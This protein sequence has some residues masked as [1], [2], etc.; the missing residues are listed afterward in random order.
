MVTD[1][2]S[3][4][5]DCKHLEGGSEQS[6]AQSLDT[7]LLSDKFMLNEWMVIVLNR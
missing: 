2:L 3:S 4:P 6:P 1:A 7:S 5:L